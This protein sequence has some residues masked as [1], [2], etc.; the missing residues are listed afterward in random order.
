MFYNKEKK[1]CDGLGCATESEEREIE[2]K[3]MRFASATYNIA[4]YL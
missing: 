3:K 4:K 1:Q 2:I